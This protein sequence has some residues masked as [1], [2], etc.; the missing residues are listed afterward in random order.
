MRKY[1]T[2]V[3]RTGYWRRQ[4]KCQKACP[5]NTDARGYIRAIAAGNDELAYLI[6]R[7]PNPLAS[8]CGRV[9]G[10]PC[11]TACRRGDFDESVSIRALKRYACEGFGP[12]ARPEGGKD[13]VEFIKSA[14]VSYD[15]RRC[16]AAEEL[17]PLMD[18]LSG[19]KVV[20]VT[21]KS[22]G[23]IGAGPAGLAAAHDLALLGFSVTIYEM[24]S[25]LGG[26]L[27]V[28]I[29]DYRLPRDLIQAEVD[30]ILALG[31]ESVTNCCVGRDVSLAELRQKHDALV[32][33]V[34]AKKSR[35]SPYPGS[36]AKGVFGGVE[37]LREVAVGKAPT[38][39]QRVVVVGGGDAAMDSAR[40]ALRVPGQE[41]DEAQEQGEHYLAMDA[42]R[43]ASRMGGR[44]IDL[45]QK[46]GQ[47]VNVAFPGVRR[48]RVDVLVGTRVATAVR[49]GAVGAPDLG[50]VV[51]P[52]AQVAGAA[53]DED[54]G[55][56][57]A[58]L[59]VGEG[60]SVDVDSLYTFERIGFHLE[61]SSDSNRTRGQVAASM[62]EVLSS[63]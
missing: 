4:I 51:V 53:V 60:G 52:G 9:C 15:S 16:N 62:V 54:D 22:V 50:Q 1:Q 3:P 30:A 25:M 37:F 21:G 48:L 58:L 47:I 42:A 41:D 23:I 32:I 2:E 11:E 56:A 19:E 14:S 45:L 17:L 59:A 29:P 6:A 55:L 20:P 8:I 40:T 10:A 39:G 61:F 49:D 27:A 33:A 13:L 43:T 5:V 26:M 36:D 63:G 31:V 12:E 57:F 38:L 24:E 44:S 35:K 28:G 18:S 46:R 34:G 7:G